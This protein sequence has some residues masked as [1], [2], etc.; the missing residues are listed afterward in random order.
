MFPVVFHW[1]LGARFSGRPMTMAPKTAEFGH[2]HLKHGKMIIKNTSTV[3]G[4][5]EK[6]TRLPSV[7]FKM[8]GLDSL[9]VNN[10]NVILAILKNRPKSSSFKSGCNMSTINH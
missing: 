8:E 3:V 4:M 6:A 5:S 9:L 1:W 7:S 2:S 10:V